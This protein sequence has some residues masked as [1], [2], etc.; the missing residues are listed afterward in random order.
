MSKFGTCSHCGNN[1]YPVWFIEEE[2]VIDHRFHSIVKTGRKRRAVDYLECL[3]C[4]NKECVDDSFDEPWED[5][6]NDY[7]QINY[8]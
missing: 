2:T 4:G 8:L 5:Q 7:A 1:L 6:K 3:C